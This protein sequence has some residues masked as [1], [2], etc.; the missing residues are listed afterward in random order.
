MIAQDPA[1]SVKVLRAVN[2]PFYG[3]SQKVSNVPQAVALLGMHSVKTLV[4]GFSL[5]SSLKNE[6]SGFDHLAYWR[7]SMFAAAAARVLACEFAAFHKE[8]CFIAALLMDIGTL[9]LDQLLGQEYEAIY[10]KAE[11]HQDLLMLESHSLGITHPE[12]GKSLAE[13]WRLPETLVIPIGAHHGPQ[14]V[15]DHILKKIT[16]IIWLA[17]RCADVFVAPREAGDAISAVRRSLRAVY[18]VDEIKTDTLMCAI[19][20]KTS[21]LA[22]LFDVRLNTSVEYTKVLEMASQR[23]LE[24]S[25]G[26][27]DAAQVDKRRSNRVRRDGKILITPCKSGVLDAPIQVKLRDLSAT[28]IGLTHTDRVEVGT[29]FI[30]QLPQPK[31][32]VKSLLYT[33][34]RC[35]TLGSVTS[36]G[37]ELV[38]V[39]RPAEPEPVLGA[40]PAAAA[41]VAAAG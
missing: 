13:H 30:I 12:A 26:E 10:E 34:K 35:D 33:V 3:L 36:I 24:L 14:E 1:L 15:E 9:L 16:Q 28:G 29:Q 11:A 18:N 37:A 21:Q 23:L 5:I 40:S 17:G 7:R 6:K 20:Q 8:E 31:G 4:L 32:P 2:S 25:I 22:S 38:S 41:P 19:G 39:L 27:R